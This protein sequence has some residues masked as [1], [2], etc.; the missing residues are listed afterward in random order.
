M[1]NIDI[2]SRMRAFPAPAC[3]CRDDGGHE[4][5]CL[6][7][8]LGEG[9]AE[10]E[11][12]RA[13]NKRLSAMTAL[14]GIASTRSGDRNIW[15][16]LMCYFGTSGVWNSEDATADIAALDLS[17]SLKA[18]I[19]A[20]LHSLDH[21]QT[22]TQDDIA[23]YST[24]AM[25]VARRIKGERPDWRVVYIDRTRSGADIRNKDYFELDVTI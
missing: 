11:R 22:A 1:A 8:I 15:V 13:E 21:V 23:F 20:W 17:S 24:L 14:G 25:N 10:I 3:L 16:R 7:A 2:L 4:A 6:A 9:S 12:L 18:E 5:H 19:F